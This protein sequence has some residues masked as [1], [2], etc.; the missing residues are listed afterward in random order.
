MQKLKEKQQQRPFAN[1]NGK[2]TVTIE[3]RLRLRCVCITFF[4]PESVFTSF[5]LCAIFGMA[6]QKRRSGTKASSEHVPFVQFHC[7]RAEENSIGNVVN[8]WTFLA[9]FVHSLRSTVDAKAKADDDMGRTH[10]HKKVEKIYFEAITK[11]YIMFRNWEPEAKGKTIKKE[12]K[13]K[14]ET[15]MRGKE[16][17]GNDPRRY[18]NFLP[19]SSSSSILFV[20]TKMSLNRWTIP[21]N[22]CVRNWC[23]KYQRR[24]RKRKKFK[25]KIHL[26]FAVHFSRVEPKNRIV[27]SKQE[28]TNSTKL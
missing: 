12:M 3:A 1:H 5:R 27:C 28:R 16:K 14:G 22:M 23:E 10:T 15:T 9:N 13:K 20:S 6:W 2:W 19:F 24:E 17:R 11:E 18:Q 21:G 25:F 26:V 8:S 4:V 7:K